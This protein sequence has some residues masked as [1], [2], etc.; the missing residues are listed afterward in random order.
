MVRWINMPSH[1]RAVKGPTDPEQY[2]WRPTQKPPLSVRNRGKPRNRRL[3]APFVCSAPRA[4][5]CRRTW[6]RRTPR[7]PQ[8]RRGAGTLRKRRVPSPGEPELM[9]GSTTGN[10][11]KEK[12]RD[13]RNGGKPH[14]QGAKGGWRTRKMG[15]KPTRTQENCG[16]TSQ[17][18]L[19]HGP[20]VNTH[21]IGSKPSKGQP[22]LSC[23]LVFLIQNPLGTTKSLTLPS[24]PQPLESVG[25][26]PRLLTRLDSRQSALGL[27]RPEGF[28]A[29]LAHGVGVGIPDLLQL[30]ASEGHLHGAIHALDGAG[31]I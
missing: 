27:S 10:G 5:R 7:P 12:T 29:H 21:E 22:R 16:L 28:E 15:W 31:W 6:R 23:H 18:F 13:P 8:R 11:E 9:E 30:P 4:G 17:L 19:R 25:H 14:V 20:L 3:S 26:P 1:P 24:P 2:L